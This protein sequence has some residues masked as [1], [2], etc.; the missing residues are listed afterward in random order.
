MGPRQCGQ[1]WTA[2]TSF[3]ASFLV[4]ASFLVAGDGVTGRRARRRRQAVARQRS[5][6]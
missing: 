6:Q 2:L 1:R 5:E 3:A 4:S